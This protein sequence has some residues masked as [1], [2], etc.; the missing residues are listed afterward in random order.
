[1]CA[2]NTASAS[3]SFR[4]CHRLRTT[5]TLS[6]PTVARVSLECARHRRTRFERNNILHAACKAQAQSTCAGAHLQHTGVRPNSGRQKLDHVVVRA[7]SGTEAVD[8]VSVRIVIRFPVGITQPKRLA[9][10]GILRQSP[11]VAGR[12]THHSDQKPR[13]VILQMLRTAGVESIR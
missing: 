2:A 13:G 4:S 1:M 12:C 3:G 10:R 5:R 6:A 7:L 9:A 8:A 11:A